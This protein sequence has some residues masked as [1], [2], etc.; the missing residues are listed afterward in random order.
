[1]S[2]N[3]IT[4]IKNKR[5]KDNYVLVSALI[6]DDFGVVIETSIGSEFYLGKRV[7]VNQRP[8]DVH[9]I[10]YEDV[11]YLICHKNRIMASW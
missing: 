5:I 11:Y 3:I 9:V 2:D 7:I 8:S 4:S 10:S 1:M 6:E